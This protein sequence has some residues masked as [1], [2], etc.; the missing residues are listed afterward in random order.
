MTSPALGEARGSVR[1]LLTKNGQLEGGGTL[2]FPLWKRLTFKRLILTKSGFTNLNVFFKD[3]SIDNN[4]GYKTSPWCTLGTGNTPPNGHGKV[5]VAIACSEFLDGAEEPEMGSEAGRLCA[6]TWPAPPKERLSARLS[7]FAE[8]VA[9]RQGRG[10]G[11]REEVLDESSK[12]NTRAS[13]RRESDAESDSC[14]DAVSVSSRRGT[15]GAVKRPRVDKGQGQSSSSKVLEAPAPPK[16]PTAARGRNSKRLAT[17]ARCEPAERV[18]AESGTLRSAALSDSSVIEVLD[19]EALK[20]GRS[21]ETLRQ[22]VREGLRQVAGKKPQSA[23]AAQ[24]KSVETEIMAA[25]FNF[26]QLEKCTRGLPKCGETWRVYRPLTQLWRQSFGRP[27]L[28]L[29]FTEAN[30]NPRRSPTCSG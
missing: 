5:G 12:P 4:H 13:S 15:R 30:I 3:L 16:I 1:L 26:P 14:V 29:P 28:N 24:L 19:D 23:V 2:I 17:T 20:S 25:V 18:A 9:E 11:A 7:D 22:V 10:S 8:S 6:D 27:R 21:S